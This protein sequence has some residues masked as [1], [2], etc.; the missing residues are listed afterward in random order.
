MCRVVIKNDTVYSSGLDKSV[1]AWSITNNHLKYEFTHNVF[2]FDFVI[3]RNGSPLNNKIVS[4]SY[5]NSCRI[6]CRISNLETGDEVKTINVDTSC[7]SVSVD[8]AQT[9]I[10]IGAE[11]KVIFIETTNFTKV[12]E[13]S[14]NNAVLS[15]A[16]NNRND[17]MLAV[18]KNGEVH[19]IKF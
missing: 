13:V 5:D 18:T 14:L 9:L 10:A 1:K 17:Y 16:F 6:S 19:S 12:K 2:V 4:I 7:W 3:G 11:S 15:L 8:K